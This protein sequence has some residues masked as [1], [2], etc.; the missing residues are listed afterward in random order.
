MNKETTV[1]A[2][3]NG[4]PVT[5]ARTPSV[6][7][8]IP[9]RNEQ[10]VIGQCLEH[11]A[12]LERPRR[13]VEVILVDN[14]STD[15]TVRIACG[16]E[17]RL[18]LRVLEQAEGYISSMRNAGA[19][20]ARGT[21]LAFLDADCLAPPSWLN[22]VETALEAE[23]TGAIGAFYAIPENSS[24]VARAWYS[25]GQTMARSTVSFLP[26]GNFLMREGTFWQV[27]GFDERIQTNE[28]YELCQ[29]ILAAGLRLRSVPA[30]SVVHL[31]TPQTLAAFYH[32][33]RWHGLHVFR[34]FLRDLSKFHNGRAVA[35]AVYMLAALAGVTA[36]LVAA[37][38]GDLRWLGLAAAAFL[39]GPALVAVQAANSRKKWADLLPL[40]VLAGTYGV[41]RALCLLNLRALRK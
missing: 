30:M 31:G 26:A 2:V 16:F 6:S 8:I 23:S 35:F 19:R 12:R 5:P 41:A 32:K 34:V 29:R 21:I 3:S 18:N 15:D 10:H 7:V 17:D 27:G 1:S 25:E 20:S 37:A 11:L 22:D 13:E 9:A 40:V 4:K 39:A 38:A 28:D 14:G 36:G 33:Q 24:W